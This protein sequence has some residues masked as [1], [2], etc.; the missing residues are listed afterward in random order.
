[1][2]LP[3]WSDRGPDVG[4]GIAYIGAGYDEPLSKDTAKE[5]EGLSLKWTEWFEHG[6][7]WVSGGL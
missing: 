4:G 1:M 3:R 7:T 6:F 5:T 2:S